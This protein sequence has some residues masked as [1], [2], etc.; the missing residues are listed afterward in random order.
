MSSCAN[1]SRSATGAGSWPVRAVSGRTPWGESTGH[2]WHPS[3]P[4]V[5]PLWTCKPEGCDALTNF[6]NAAARCAARSVFTH[7]RSKVACGTTAPSLQIRQRP[8][9]RVPTAWPRHLVG[10]AGLERPIEDHLQRTPVTSLDG[11]TLACRLFLF[12]W[13]RLIRLVQTTELNAV[14]RTEGAG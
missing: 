5:S 9:H 1:F 13:S 10:N 3:H 8:H 11:V 7:S 14:A 6:E 2:A 12:T 4:S